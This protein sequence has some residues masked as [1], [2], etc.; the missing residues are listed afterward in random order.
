MQYYGHK[1]IITFSAIVNL[2]LLQKELIV[3]KQNLILVPN[4]LLSA[5]LIS[6]T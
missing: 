6:N 2:P 5:F 4:S 3:S 1:I